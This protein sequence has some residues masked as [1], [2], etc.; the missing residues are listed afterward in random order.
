ME[1]GKNKRGKRP[2]RKE[3]K[4]IRKE[5][6]KEEVK[7]DPIDDI[8]EEEEEEQEEVKE[9]KP[10]VIQ[11]VENKPAPANL[12]LNPALPPR[13]PKTQAEKDSQRRLIVVLEGANLETVKTREG[14]NLLNCDD[15]AFLL[16]KQE[17]DANEARPDITHQ[18]LLTLLDSPINKSGHLQIYIHTVHNVLIEV[19]PRIRIPRTFPRF[20]GLMVQLLQ[21]LSIRSSE[22]A[23]RL[24]RVIQNPVTKY[25]P[26]KCLKIGTEYDAKKLVDIQDYVQANFK[27]KD[28]PVVFVIGAFAHGD[29]KADYLDETISFSSY[30]LSASVACGKVAFAFE[31][32]WDIV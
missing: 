16:R 15:H 1:N 6:V 20:S 12:I 19:N 31:K 26:T 29:V 28:E 9:E 2:Q 22:G 27:G 13:L 32:L 21:K 24:M 18:C 10:N 4:K 7:K 11:L 14:F 25:F 17:K 8:E 5:P 3:V 23:E 30:P